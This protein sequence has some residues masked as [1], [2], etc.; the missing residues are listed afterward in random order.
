MKISLVFG[1][2]EEF[3]SSQNVKNF[4]VKILDNSLQR[5]SLEGQFY[6]D[7]K[8]FSLQ[9]FGEES[10]VLEFTNYLSKVIPLSLQWGFKEMKILGEDEVSN[11]PPLEI[12]H[13]SFSSYLSALEL[14]V[15]TDKNNENFCNLWGDFINFT[16]TPLSFFSSEGKKLI[17][18]KALLEDSLEHLSQALKKKQRVFL[19]T[20]YGKRELVLLDEKNPAKIEGDYWFMP[21]CLNNAQ[22][23]FKTSQEELQALATLEKPLIKLKPKSIF[24]EFFSQSF[25]SC[26]L[27]YEPLLVLLT[28]FLEEYSGLYLLPLK[29][30]KIELGLCYFIAQESSPT[31]VSVGKN[32]LILQHHFATTQ[33]ISHSVMKEFE[34]IILRDKL[35]KVNLLYLGRGQTRFMLYFNQSFKE[36]LEFIFESNIALRIEELKVFNKTTQSL[37][38]NFTRENQDL[39][40]E[41]ETYPKESKIS[42][43]L[44]ELI[45]MCGILLD[46]KVDSMDLMSLAYQ[47]LECASNFVGQK[48]PRIDFKLERNDEG[49]VYLDTLKTLR[50]VMSF[51]L[52]GVEK[53]LLCFGIVDSFAEFF[54]NF[55]RDMEESYNTKG[56]IVCGEIFLNKQFLDQFIHYLPK[57]SEMFSTEIIDFLL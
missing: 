31:F 45:G 8:E 7:D 19:K 42:S 37:L 48:G 32:S 17:D 56:I 34:N 29:E 39:I 44:L 46:F 28:K 40:S 13:P 36:P 4:I 11:E 2:I 30:E 26:V 38:K 14:Q 22:I 55:S 27:P 50:S 35:E 51:K 16:Q 53:E 12:C 10:V 54:A 1:F 41:L 15:I 24:M 49:K 18:S 43:N 57:N 52:A 6:G 25:V 9:V 3:Q 33:D 47:V 21:F 5:Y 20:I 23:F